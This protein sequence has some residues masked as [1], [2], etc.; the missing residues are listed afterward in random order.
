MASF[1]FLILG[2]MLFFF[3]FNF[4]T[5][6][7]DVCFGLFICGLTMLKKFFYSLFVEYFYHEGVL[8]FMEC[9]LCHG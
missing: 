9:F 6:E 3:F 2:E 7:Y 4:F 1:S 5:I 8:N